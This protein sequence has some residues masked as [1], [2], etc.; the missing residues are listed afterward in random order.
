MP[1]IKLSLPHQLSPDEA[2]TRISKLLADTRS[3]FGDQ[4]SDVQETWNGNTDTFS[5][6][7]LG[8]SVDGRLEVQPGE[9]SVDMNLPWA[10]LPFKGR[11]ESEIRRHGE[12]L[13][14]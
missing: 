9:V 2:R 10:A 11:I 7:A 13:L 4:L 8:F 1:K 14:A 5:F 12:Q 3:K 6:R